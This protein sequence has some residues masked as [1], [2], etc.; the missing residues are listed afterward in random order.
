MGEVVLI[1]DSHAGAL[2]D[3]LSSE[4]LELNVSGMSFVKPGCP[5]VSD[6]IMDPVEKFNCNEFNQIIDLILKDNPCFR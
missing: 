1:G 5:P 2:K 6:I 4:L 3:S